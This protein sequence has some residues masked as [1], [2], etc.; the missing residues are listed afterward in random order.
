MKII[1]V[2]QLLNESGRRK[3]LKWNYYI[4]PNSK[5][6]WKCDNYFSFLR[7]TKNFSH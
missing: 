2:R 3:T 6:W 5:Y 1:D 7:E 4:H